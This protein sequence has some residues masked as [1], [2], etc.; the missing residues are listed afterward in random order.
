MNSLL[1]VFAHLQFI[2]YFNWFLISPFVLSYTL[3][4]A[5]KKTQHLSIRGVLSPPPPHPLPLM[6][7]GSKHKHTVAMGNHP[8]CHSD[9]S[10]GLKLD[11]DQTTNLPGEGGVQGGRTTTT[12]KC[13]LRSNPM[14][15]TGVQC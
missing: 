4:F 8:C 7:S 9:N 1:F 12:D 15:S 14:F 10:S 13:T 11:R 2:C 6:A 5:L 3:V